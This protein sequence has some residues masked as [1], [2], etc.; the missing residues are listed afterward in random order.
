[1][2]AA[3]RVLLVAG[4]LLIVPRGSFAQVST[5]IIRGRVTDPDAHPVQGVE[6]RATSYQGRVTKIATT[7]K[8]GRFT[9]IYINGEG[10][11]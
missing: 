7:D 8:G 4:M 2:S 9:I 5:D 6:V 3:K 10:D 1:M 11:Y